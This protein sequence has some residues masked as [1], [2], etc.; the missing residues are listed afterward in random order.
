MVKKKNNYRN[1]FEQVT[2]D[3]LNDKSISFEYETERLSY[4]ITANYIPDFILFTRSG[5]KIY[6]ETKGNGRSFDG[7]S[8]RKLIAVRSQHPEKDIRIVFWSDG[9]F[10]ATRKDGT[11]QTQCGWATKNGFLCAVREI[12]DAWLQ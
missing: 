6:I 5:R 4:T 11:R 9:K 8:R 7:A 3:S 10:G 2:G 1:K 12:P